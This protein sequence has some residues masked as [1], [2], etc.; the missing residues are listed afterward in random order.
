MSLIDP[1][2]KR[3]ITFARATKDGQ[4]ASFDTAEI[5]KLTITT[6]V[7]DTKIESDAKSPN[8]N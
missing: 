4:T 1:E 5:G 3:K 6:E 8:A 2:S 7:A